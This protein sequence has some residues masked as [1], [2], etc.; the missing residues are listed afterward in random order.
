M[1]RLSRDFVRREKAHAFMASLDGARVHADDV[2]DKLTDLLKDIDVEKIG[3]IPQN[4][5]KRSYVWETIC[6]IAKTASIVGIWSVP[7][8]RMEDYLPNIDHEI[9]RERWRSCQESE[10]SSALSFLNLLKLTSV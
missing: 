8:K 2:E 5:Q 9:F 1:S 10:H 4:F 6:I 7:I 3:H